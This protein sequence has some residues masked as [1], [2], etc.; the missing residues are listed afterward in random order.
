MDRKRHKLN[1]T[2][3][4]LLVLLFFILVFFVCYFCSQSRKDSKQPLL[5]SINI[6]SNNIVTII[7]DK[8][9]EAKRIGIIHGLEIYQLSSTFDLEENE[10]EIIIKKDISNYKEKFCENCNYKIEIKWY[11]G[12]LNLYT[13]YE[14]DQFTILKESYGEGF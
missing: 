4:F 5:K 12:Q 7:L 13:L 11:G 3:C 8:T 10:D 6:D 9:N 1:D 2:I 14:N